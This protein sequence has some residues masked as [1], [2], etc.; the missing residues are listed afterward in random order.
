MPDQQERPAQPGQQK[1]PQPGQA[2]HPQRIRRA[3]VPRLNRS[4][5]RN[6]A[7]KR[8]WQAHESVDHRRYE[9][10]KRGRIGQRED[11][12]KNAHSDH[13]GRERNREI[14]HNLQTAKCV[15]LHGKCDRKSRYDRQSGG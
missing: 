9:E 13:Q 6:K 3:S 7:T 5:R 12:D 4:N 1:P 2:P 11:N 14:A 15:V 8:K 10:R